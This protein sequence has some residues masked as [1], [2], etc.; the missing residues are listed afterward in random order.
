MSSIQVTRRPQP[1][2]VREYALLTPLMGGGPFEGLPD[3]DFPVAGKAVRGQLRFWWRALRGGQFG[4]DI[5]AMRARERALFGG[6]SLV[7]GDPDLP[8]P[9]MVTALPDA[10]YL[11]REMDIPEQN[12]LLGY[13]AF[14]LRG[15]ESL[16]LGRS[17][18]LLR[19]VRFTLRLSWPGRTLPE[20]V[21]V[22]E[23]EQALWAWETFGGV[24]ARTRRGF[25]AVGRTDAA[26][27]ATPLDRHVNETLARHLTPGPWP[28][29]IPHLTSDPDDRVV[30]VSNR[31]PEEEHRMLAEVLKR[32]RRSTHNSKF[33]GATL[34][35]EPDSILQAPHAGPQ[36]FPR[37]ALGLPIE[38]D[39]NTSLKG[40]DV[41]R[42][43]SPVL[44]R[45]A[46]Y[47]TQTYRVA[48]RLRSEPTAADPLAEDG[49]L[50]LTVK[51]GRVRDT[52][53]NQR[54]R[55]STK[56]AAEITALNQVKSTD[57]EAEVDVAA[58]LMYA[59]RN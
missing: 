15:K 16:V 2:I 50:T 46:R 22:E 32:F 34:W 26:S 9:F 55:L 19:D 29:G 48:V 51:K 27:D 13:L 57:T 23:I 43:A 17:V 58:A 20:A 37:A 14:G 53:P 11:P 35:P 5:D 44:F 7:S 42:L 25:G 56:E 41:D 31:S 59:L 10:R 54:Y 12:S 21:D 24:G 18:K 1:E 47:G 33:E 3:L 30:K 36:V 49:R 45:P 8:S 40:T 6:V 38:F 4:G 39:K 28:A 52:Y